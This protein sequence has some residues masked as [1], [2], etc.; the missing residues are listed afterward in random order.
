MGVAVRSWN[1][2][3]GFKILSHKGR[4]LDHMLIEHV[5]L[6]KSDDNNKKTIKQ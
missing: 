3:R 1:R 6:L 5:K 2:R 4:M